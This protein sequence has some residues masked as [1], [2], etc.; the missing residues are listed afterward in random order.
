[1]LNGKLFWCVLN[2]EWYGMYE[3]V[4]ICFNSMIISMKVLFVVV[5]WFSMNCSLD[6]SLVIPFDYSFVLNGIFSIWRIVVVF[7]LFNR[8]KCYDMLIE[9]SVEMLFQWKW[10]GVVVFDWFL[11]ILCDIELFSIQ[12]IWNGI[13]DWILLLFHLTAHDFNWIMINNRIEV[14]VI[15][16]SELLMR[17]NGLIDGI[18]WY[19]MVVM[20]IPIWSNSIWISFVYLNMDRIEWIV[21]STFNSLRID[22]YNPCHF[23]WF[24]RIYVIEYEMKCNCI[25]GDEN[26]PHVKWNGW[27]RIHMIVRWL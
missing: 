1:M 14:C 21:F 27:Y 17:L 19:E 26:T 10:E 22:S 13:I 3:I 8:N 5:V 18:W 20:N 24:E 2:E 15:S 4:D 16:I 11:G 7:I 6:L 9:N 12:L 25:N 23:G